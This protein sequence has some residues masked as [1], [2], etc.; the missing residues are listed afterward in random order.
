MLIIYWALIRSKSDLY[1]KFL[2]NKQNGTKP[3]AQSTLS[4]NQRPQSKGQPASSENEAEE[5]EKDVTPDA[6][7]KDADPTENGKEESDDSP[8]R[9]QKRRTIE[10][11]E[12]EDDSDDQPVVK[13]RRRT[14]ASKEDG[15]SRANKS[16]SKAHGV[17]SR[18]LP[19]QK[20]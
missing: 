16:T 6:E 3:K 9:K 8:T 15:K 2:G 1:R 20:K 12:D 19:A 17:K 11:E 5:D 10:S 4:F 13:R 18:D 7:M 14:S